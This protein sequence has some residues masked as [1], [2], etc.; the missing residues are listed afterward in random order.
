MPPGTRCF[1]TRMKMKPEKLYLYRGSGTDPYQNLALEHYFTRTVPEGSLLL[2]LWQ[3]QRTVVVGRNQNLIAQCRTDQLLKDGG[4]P[5]RRLSGGGAVYHDL[6]NLNFSFCACEGV[7]DVAAQTRMICEAI[8]SFG[9]E[10]KV[11]GRNDIMADGLKVS[12]GA[13]L[14]EGRRYC[15]HG[16]LMVN[17]NVRDMARYLTPP[18]VKLKARG[19]ASVRSRVGNLH[20]MCPEVTVDSLA[21]ALEEAA[22]KACGQKA[23]MVEESGIDRSWTD[24]EAARFASDEWLYGREPR[25]SAQ[26]SV[27]RFDWG[28][29]RLKVAAERGIVTKA[30]LE[31]DANDGG[32]AGRVSALFENQ[33][34]SREAMCLKARQ[35]GLSESGDLAV[36]VEDMFDG[37]V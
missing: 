5:A 25:L 29:A 12:G 15:H 18:A 17:V 19:V 3:N 22:E 7:Y 37:N 30:V 23:V 33:P 32:L 35:S 31:T 8:S 20:A 28:C 13:Y 27:R 16:T 21:L 34:F 6:G 4:H 24:R 14:Q 26:S 1:G 36:L 2:Y 11:S 10:A 9:I